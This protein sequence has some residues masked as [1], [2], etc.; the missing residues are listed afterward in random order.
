[1]ENILSSV[2]TIN[3]AINGFVW[4]LPMLIL[5][6]GTGILMTCLTKFFQITHFKHWVSNTIGGIFKDSHVT[7]HTHKNDTQISQFQSLC[8]ALAATI[9]TGNIAGVA[10]A[11]AS[12]GPGAIFWMWIVAFFGMMTNFSENVLGIYYRRRNERNE[13][14]GGAMYYLHDG[15]GAKPGCKQIGAVLA[16]MFSVFCI[17]ASFGIGNMGQVNSIAVNIKSAFGIPSIVTG[18]GLMI[19]GGLVIVGGLKRIAAVT[20]KLVPFMAVI[21]MICAIIVCLVHI[22]Q[23]GA[24]FIS[25]IKGA[26]GM[27]AVGGGIVGSG[28][29]MAV[30]WGM[31]RGV[32]SN[33]AGLGSSV[34]VHSSSNVREPVVQGMWGIFEVFADTIIVCTITAFAVLSSGLVD[35]E[36]GVVISDQVSTALVA[37]AFSTVF[38]KFGSAFIAI[39]ILLFAFSTTLGWSQYGSKGFEYLFGRKNIKFYQIVFVL[40]IVVGATMDL[41]LAWDISDTLNGMMAIPNLIGVLALSGTVMKITHNYVQRNLLNQD[42]KPMLSAIDDIQDLHEQE[43]KASK[44]KALAKNETA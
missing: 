21:Y 33:E 40:F 38:G 18:I 32:F 37:E 16:V 17:G 24:V 13:W 3:N 42:V 19:L 29:A 34:M 23:F 26:F 39:A 35:L 41:S 15:L 31:K 44:E 9:G 25:I 4:G 2:E 11:I 1:M 5:L 28:V 7:A 27:R 43:L 12:G 14:C 10:A 20:E 36:T 22:D 6:V 30:Q 8:T